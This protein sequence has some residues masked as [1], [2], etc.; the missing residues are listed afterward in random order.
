MGLPENAGDDLERL[1]RTEIDMMIYYI[2][3][4]GL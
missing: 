1:P 3:E 4:D 2:V